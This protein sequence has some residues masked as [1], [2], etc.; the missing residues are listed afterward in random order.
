MFSLSVSVCSRNQYEC[1]STREC[2]AIYNVCDGIPQCADGS[3]ESS[4]LGCP[5]EKP[6][7]PPQT[8]LPKPLLPVIA[9]MPNYQMLPHHKSYASSYEH[10]LE[11]ENGK[12]WPGQNQMVPGQMNV[13]YPVDRM[14]PQVNVGYPRYQWNYPPYYDPNKDPY[15][16]NPPHGQK[17]IPYEREYLIK[18]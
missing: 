14:M 18:N 10:N 11:Q 2:I 13:Q 15:N 3:D 12:S 7:M 5:T 8:L 17:M 9:D 4:D 16:M 1:K 6:T